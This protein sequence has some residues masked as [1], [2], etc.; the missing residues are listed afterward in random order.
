MSGVQT[1]AKDK[2]AAAS[3]VKQTKVL[4][5]HY[6]SILN[7][8]M[9]VLILISGPAILAYTTKYYPTFN[10]DVALVNSVIALVIIGVAYA[11]YR[12]TKSGGA[13]PYYA[14]ILFF[15][16]IIM[17][18]MYVSKYYSPPVY[19]L[20]IIPIQDKASPFY[21]GDYHIRGY[22]EGLS[23]TGILIAI[24]SL[25]EIAVIRITG[26]QHA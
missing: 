10:A 16:G 7:L 26:K 19:A 22:L 25:Y 8:A 15:L 21:I 24:A 6:I 9:G 1:P 4:P 13:K 5:A 17:Q 2:D 14:I 18:L 11:D 3:Q 12:N 20:H 23:F